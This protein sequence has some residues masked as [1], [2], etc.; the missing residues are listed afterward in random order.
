MGDH[1][2]DRAVKAYPKPHRFRSQGY[3][4]FLRG[5]PCIQCGK[6]G[7]LHHVSLKGGDRA[8]GRKPPD[9]RVVP[10]CHE[11]HMFWENHPEIEKKAR[12]TLATIMVE[13]LSEYVEHLEVK[14]GG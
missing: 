11:C 12:L 8:W 2:M 7:E 14:R 9:S 13:Q 10:L 6:P 4:T 5:R 1:P 3:L